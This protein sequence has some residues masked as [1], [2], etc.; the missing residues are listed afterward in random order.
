[1]KISVIGLG[2]LGASTAFFLKDKGINVSGYDVDKKILNLL[3]KNQ[4]LFYE[5]SLENL[6]KKYKIKI[7]YDVNKL[8]LDS[9][10][11]YIIVPTPSKKDGSFSDKIVK[12]VLNLTLKAIR[13]KKKPHNIILTSTVSPGTCQN[14]IKYFEK[15]YKIQDGKN[16]RFFYNPYFIALG[17]IIWNLENP[18]FLLVGCK[19]Q[20]QFFYKK[21]FKKLY[22]VKNIPI[23]FLN[24][25]EA[26]IT[27]ISINC[28]VT[29]KISFTNSIS[30]IADNLKIQK[31]NAEK[32]LDAI[33][34]DMRINKKYLGL[35]TMF[36]GPCF[37]R[38][39]TAMINFFSKVKSNSSLFKATSLIND[40]QAARYLKI[41]KKYPKSKRIGFLG[42]TYKSGTDLFTDSPAFYLYKRFN[43]KFKNFYGYDPYF[44][45]DTINQINKNYKSFLAL[46][47]Y[48]KFVSSCDIIIL[49]YKDV[50]FKKL[51]KEKNKLIID[52]WN[53]LKFSKKTKYVSLGIN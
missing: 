9:D 41:I 44:R 39:N 53:Y 37:P 42:L 10:T 21:L 14:L 3:E 8:L 29:M 16:F 26:E 35:G 30:S 15:K 11:T 13:K 12:N 48:N 23:K 38:D 6:L 27:K 36:S 32:I 33:G 5:K 2:K 31:I 40:Y 18:D 49:C 22:G 46:S 24:L 7:Y 52:P 45:E 17:D 34:S 4:T 1:M 28:Y 50:K 20:N 19:L 43:S 25:T 51:L 47:N